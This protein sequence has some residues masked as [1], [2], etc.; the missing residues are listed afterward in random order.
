MRIAFLGPVGTHTEEALLRA[1]DTAG[2][3]LLPY[4]TVMDV[5]HAVKDGGADKGIVPIENS[6][7]GSVAA[8]LDFLAFE[9][10]LLIEQEVL[11]RIK[12]GLIGFSD[13]VLKDVDTVISHPQAAAQCRMFLR[14][15][16]GTDETIAANSTADAVRR[17]AESG[18]RTSVAIGTSLA[19]RLHGLAILLETIAD[20]EDNVTRFVIVGHEPA[21]K[22]GYDKTSLVCFI[23]HD[24]PGSLLG[25]LQEFSYRYIN[26]TKIVSRPTKKNL[27]DYCFF[28]DLEGHI[29]DPIVDD[30]IRCLACKLPQVKVLGSYSREA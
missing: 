10:D 9:S 19:A 13:T 27:G 6:V 23:H 30:A 12:H 4:P 25:I 17:V 28:I 21:P 20:T 22:T 29:T 26:L 24:R 8:T 5:L 18:S 2:D 16:F 3:E 15:T 7:E 1:R 14:R 11:H